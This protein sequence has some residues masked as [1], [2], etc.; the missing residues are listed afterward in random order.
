MFNKKAADIN[1]LKCFSFVCLQLSII[2]ANK[3]QLKHT[4]SALLKGRLP[5]LSE[6]IRP[7]ANVIKPFRLNLRHYHRN[8]S[9]ILKAMCQ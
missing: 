8:L 7:V 1:K 6:N 2:F 5:A 4:S 9:Q 3:T